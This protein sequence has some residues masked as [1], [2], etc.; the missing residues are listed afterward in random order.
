MEKSQIA[1]VFHHGYPVGQQ[2]VMGR[3]PVR[4]IPVDR[5]GIYPHHA[6]SL[7]HKIGGGRGADSRVVVAKTALLWTECPILH[8]T[9]VEQ[10]PIARANRRMGLLPCLNVRPFQRLMFFQKCRIN[11]N[12]RTAQS[13]QRHP[14]DHLIP[15]LI[16]IVTKRVHMGS[17]MLI[18]N[19]LKIIAAVP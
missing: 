1:Q 3:V 17:I 8:P 19:E 13:R 7:L 5:Q 11:G 14:V 2:R 12:A 15:R 9:K 6:H 10:H 4:S 18:Q 16:N